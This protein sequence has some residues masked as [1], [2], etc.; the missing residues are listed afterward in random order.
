MPFGKN[1]SR[2]GVSFEPILLTF[3]RK[4][5][6]MD[7]SI[8][9]RRACQCCGLYARRSLCR[10]TRIRCVFPAALVPWFGLLPVSRPDSRA[11]PEA[12]GLARGTPDSISLAQPTPIA[13]YGKGKMGKKKTPG[14]GVICSKTG[15]ARKV[16]FSKKD[17]LPL[18]PYRNSPGPGTADGILQRYIFSRFG[19]NE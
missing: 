8:R 15:V 13:Q 7:V 6:K 14:T 11:A 3:G 18:N 19:G 4:K 16:Y 12:C 17:A 10:K 1:S 2:C 9:G 5:V